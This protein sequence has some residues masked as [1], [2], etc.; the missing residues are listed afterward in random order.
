METFYTAKNEL[1]QRF[2]YFL[3]HFFLS[4]IVPYQISY[5]GKPLRH[6]QRK[7]A[8][9]EIWCRKKYGTTL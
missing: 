8:C 3:R 4:Q 5:F 6:W 1:L 9:K 7:I 2:Q